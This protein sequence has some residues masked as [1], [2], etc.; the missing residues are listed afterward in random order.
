MEILVCFGIKFHVQ[1]TILGDIIVVLFQSSS[2][3]IHYFQSDLKFISRRKFSPVIFI[4]SFFFSFC[5]SK[6][7][8]WAQIHFFFIWSKIQSEM[9]HCLFEPKLIYQIFSYCSNTLSILDFWCSLHWKKKCLIKLI[10]K[11]IF[12]VFI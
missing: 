12:R 11:V 2:R 10:L 8:S 9:V 4:D 3:Y 5:C 6:F 1:A 7:S